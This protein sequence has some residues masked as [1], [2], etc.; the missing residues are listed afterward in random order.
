MTDCTFCKIISDEQR[1][2]DVWEDDDYLAFLDINPIKPGH[3]LLIP[4]RHVE[5]IFDLN[6][7]GLCDL[8]VK[9][10]KLSRP[11]QT[12]TGAR[13]IGLVVEGFEVPHVH[14]HLVP[15][16]NDNE[17]NPEKGKPASDDELDAMVRK[18]RKIIE[19]EELNC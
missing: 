18:I 17:L 4:K 7:Q 15:L 6:E 3:T 9:A 16:H 13:R 19:S 1:A 14:I 10:C 11:L 12:A 8:F 2:Y 5:Y